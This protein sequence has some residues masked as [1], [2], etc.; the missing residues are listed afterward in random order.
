MVHELIGK[1]LGGYDVLDLVGEGGMA[2]VYLAR[3]QS[4]NRQVALKVLPQQFLSDD[5]YLQRFEREVK[6]V[7]KLEHRNI[8]PVYDYGEYNGQPYIAMRYMPAGSVDEMLHDGPMSLDMIVNILEQVAPA[9]DYAHTKE[10]L[11]RD[12]K[13]SNILMD[14]GGGAFITDF[15]IARII[16]E[17]GANITTHGVVGTPSYMS[18]EQA[19]GKHMDGRSDVY[20]LGVMLFE[21]ATG[22][23]PFESET[24]YSIAVMQVTQ[25]PPSPRSINPKLSEAVESVILKS[26]QKSPDDRYRTAADLLLLFKQAI[27]H[28]DSIHETERNLRKRDL[29]ARQAQ[30]NEMNV[31]QANARPAQYVPSPNPASQSQAQFTVSTP[32][33][34]NQFNTTGRPNMVSPPVSQNPVYRPPHSSDVSRPVMPS[35]ELRSQVR[36]RRQGP[37]MLGIAIGGSIGCALL[38]VILVAGFL[39]LSAMDLLGGTSRL[40]TQVPTNSSDSAALVDPVTVPA[41]TVP[42]LDAT[43]L[44]ARETIVARSTNA[45]IGT[46]TIAPP[47]ALPLSAA[48]VAPTITSLPGFDANFSLSSITGTIVFAAIS[49]DNNR[50][51]DIYTMDLA[52]RQRVALTD[53]D[54]DNSYPR[55]SPDGQWI[56]FQSERDGDF[57]IYIMD[58]NGGQVRNLTNNDYPD[59]LAAWSPDGRWIVYSSDPNRNDLFELRRV[60]ATGGEPEVLFSNGQRN[61]HPLYSPDGRYVVFTTGSDPNSGR[62]WEI[63]RLDLTNNQFVLLTQNDVRDAS[64]VFHPDGQSLLYVTFQDTGNALATMSLDGTNSRILYDTSGSDW[65]ANYSPDGQAIIFTSNQTGADE[66]YLLSADGVQVE[67]LTATGGLYASWL[68]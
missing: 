60:P 30:Y 41:D 10:V 44:A 15:G 2:T 9:L 40:S 37:P 13:P 17:H 18:P 25:A 24:P 29:E 20:S 32:Q 47:T 12:L 59:R 5:T 43:S 55:P 56:V 22:R 39:A 53:N 31:T 23:R 34:G 26:M 57:D 50:T 48:T 36:N 11:H 68:P 8:V 61:S 65:A 58:R 16:G 27:D 38:L 1:S 67:Q 19:Q 49:P 28:P 7:S 21:M 54:T 51:L 4:M 3:Q 62:T 63:G 45:D 33:T 6:I 42:T 46:S 64:A 14:D 52:T 66:L 35:A